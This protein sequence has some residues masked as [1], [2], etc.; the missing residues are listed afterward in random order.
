MEPNVNNES[1]ADAKSFKLYRG[2]AP[3]ALQ[4]IAGLMWLNGLLMI[5]GG[6]PLILLFGFGILPIVLGIFIIKYAKAVFRMQKKGYTGTLVLQGISVLFSLLSWQSAGFD[7]INTT[8][9]TSILIAFVVSGTLYLYRNQ[10][11]D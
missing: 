11:V 5:L 1:N 8:S 2:K 6:I 3:L 7:K 10:F 4:I 9:L